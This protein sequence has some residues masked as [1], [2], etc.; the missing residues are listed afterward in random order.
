[1]Q[2]TKVTIPAREVASFE[3]L[4][5]GETVENAELIPVLITIDGKPSDTL[6][7]GPESLAALRALAAEDAEEFAE[8]FAPKSAKSAA[9]RGSGKSDKLYPGTNQVINVI[10]AAAIAI[11]GTKDN[12]KPVTA[13]ARFTL[14]PETFKAIMTAHPE[15]NADAP[16]SNVAI[17]SA[18]KK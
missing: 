17:A 16:A 9:A 11:N 8:Y 5:T 6:Y 3:D 14:S 15:W 2:V 18:P 12:G 4:M 7:F 10:R 1:M 13:S